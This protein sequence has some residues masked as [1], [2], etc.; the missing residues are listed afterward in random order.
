M[1][2]LA[3]IFHCRAF[4]FLHQ[5]PIGTCIINLAS[6]S[7]GPAMEETEWPTNTRFPSLRSVS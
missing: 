1:Q 4:H 3:P 6:N 5:F 2:T 7:L